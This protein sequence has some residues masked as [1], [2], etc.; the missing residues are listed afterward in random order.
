MQLNSVMNNA[1]SAAPPSID[2][3]TPP[4]RGK[5]NWWRWFWLTTLVVS[6]GYAWY[7]FYVP[8]NSIAWAD[9][10]PAA[11]RQASQAGK[12]LI[13]FFTSKWCVPCRIMKRNVWANEQ[14][15]ASVNAGFIPVTID[16]VDPDAAAAV[17]RYRVGATPT[18]IITD[19][20]GHVLQQVAG[21]I[22]K[23]QFLEL[24]GK[25]DRTAAPIENGSKSDAVELPQE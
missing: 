6:L 13:L 22:G 9:D 18:T 12:P 2:T 23:A 25:L 14:V 15:A 7:C 17:S 21:G 5:M 4:N 1:Q 8:S 20:Q 19:S 11:Q 16:M 3:K 10:F 24:L